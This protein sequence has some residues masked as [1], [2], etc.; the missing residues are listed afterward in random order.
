MSFKPETKDELQIAV[1]LWCDNKEEALNKYG[2]I[3]T[4]NTININDMSTLFE[5]KINFNDDISNWNTSN[6]T[7]MNRMFLL[8]YRFNKLLN[9]WDVSN[10]IYINHMFYSCKSFNQSLNNWDTSNVIN[11]STVFSWCKSFNQPLIMWDIIPN[12]ISINNSLIN[13]LDDLITNPYK[14]S[15]KN[16]IINNIMSTSIINYI[17]NHETEL[18]LTK[19]KN[20]FEGYI[21]PY[22]I[23]NY[24]I[25]CVLEHLGIKMCDTINYDRFTNKLLV[26]LYINKKHKIVNSLIKYIKETDIERYSYL[27]KDL[28]KL[29]NEQLNR[30]VNIMIYND[31]IFLSDLAE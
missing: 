16:S 28:N 22:K 30:K 3:N 23:V 24:N 4:W 18:M 6:V 2:E 26:N 5:N 12:N 14:A 29:F 15:Q 7:N 27:S 9:R 10:V 31:N 19:Y 8:C 25:L 11:M 20:I 17:W 1:N 21:M 13:I